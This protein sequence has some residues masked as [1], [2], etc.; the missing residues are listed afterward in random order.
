ME[1]PG[2]ARR[3]TEL[4]RVHG[5]VSKNLGKRQGGRGYPGFVLAEAA[6]ADLAESGDK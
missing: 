5:A 6:T 4:R 1:R 3:T 2:Q